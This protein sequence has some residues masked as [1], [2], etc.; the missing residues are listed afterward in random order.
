LEE[1]D[2][3][4]RK[5]SKYTLPQD[6]MDDMYG[7]FYPKVVEELHNLKERR[8]VNGF[9][10]MVL[11]VYGFAEDLYTEM[12]AGDANLEVLG[13]GNFKKLVKDCCMQFGFSV[14]RNPNNPKV[15]E[16]GG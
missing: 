7:Y 3:K 5:Y 14:H 1:D 11:N 12:F 9:N 13:E 15:L 4:R 10:E 16:W 6:Q 8:G 2:L